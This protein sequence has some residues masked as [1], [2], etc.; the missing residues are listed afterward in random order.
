MLLDN[1]VLVQG[2]SYTSEHNTV[3]VAFPIEDDNTPVKGKIHLEK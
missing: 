3:D 1:P 2:Y